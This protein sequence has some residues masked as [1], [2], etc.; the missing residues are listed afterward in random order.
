MDN[1]I[2]HAPSY[3]QIAQALA[4]EYFSIY[5]VD[6]ET[7]GFVEYVSHRDFK[8]LQVEVD[9]ENFFEACRKNVEKVVHPDDRERLLS[10]ID[11][12][13]LIEVLQDAPSFHVIYRLLLTKGPVYVKLTAMLYSDE[14][15][16]CIILACSD[17]DSQ[18]KTE[19]KYS[20]ELGLSGKESDRDL[21]TGVKSKSAF[22]KSEELYS[23]RISRLDDLDFA[24][25]VCDV[26]DVDA[27]NTRL[28]RKAGD[29]YI[30][31][32]CALI[33]TIFC[34]SPVFRI[35]GDKFA[36][37]LEGQD[38]ELR[39]ELLNKL[40]LRNRI[41]ENTGS[42]IVAAGLSRYLRSKDLSFHDVYA[43]A[44]E[45]MYANKAELKA[46]AEQRRK[47]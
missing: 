5:C 17:V 25:A 24:I 42:V 3:A 18:V 31:E 21:L 30:K 32:G 4:A 44:E 36:A 45:A 14:A 7:D 8:E 19:T 9:G 38:F 15:H 33:C 46:R 16:R 37:I 20:E 34:H 6:I 47:G 29:L 43:R 28:G 12:K 40:S 22:T 13:H 39:D 27:V 2:S 10:A 23:E 35:S 41:N 11:K 26:N 1:F